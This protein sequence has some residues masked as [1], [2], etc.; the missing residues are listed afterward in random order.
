MKITMQIVPNIT[1]NVLV[2][3][4]PTATF[5]RSERF[6]WCAVV[7][8]LLIVVGILGGYRWQLEQTQIALEERQQLL[9]QWQ[10]QWQSTANV[11]SSQVSLETQLWSTTQRQ[12]VLLVMQALGQADNADVELLAWRWSHPLIEEQGRMLPATYQISGLSSTEASLYGYLNRLQQQLLMQN[13]NLQRLRKMSDAQDA[14]DFSVAFSVQGTA[15]DMASDRANNAVQ[16][17]D[18]AASRE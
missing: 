14:E 5:W 3:P 4:M 11:S 13:A 2:A 9:D 18:P 7:L 15:S 12:Q 10:Q 8:A 17:T 6:F 1:P 16:T